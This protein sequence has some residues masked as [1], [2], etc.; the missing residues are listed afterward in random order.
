MG[1]IKILVPGAGLGRLMYELAL[2]GYQ[3]EGNEF[4][5]FMLIASNFILNRCLLNNQHQLHPYVH[6]YVNNFNRDDQVR[7]I[8]FP[9]P[10]P[11]VQRPIGLMNMVAGDFLQVYQEENV[12]DCVATCFFIDCANNIIDFIETIFK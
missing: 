11:T 1:D 6:Q 9:D 8:M 5:L 4:S 2:I 12:W 10:S 7:S 3:C